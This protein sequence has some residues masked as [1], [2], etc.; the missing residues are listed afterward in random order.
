[1]C[2]EHLPHVSED[3][4]EYKRVHM[5]STYYVSEDMLEYSVCICVSV[6][7]CVCVCV[8]TID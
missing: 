7:V 4:L 3:M 5:M 2:D 8:C 1:M 6:L